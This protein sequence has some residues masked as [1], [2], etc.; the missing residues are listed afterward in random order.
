MSTTI[1]VLIVGAG[2]NGASVACH[3]RRRGYADRVLVCDPKGV[4]A[5]A[6][7]VAVGG[8]RNLRAHPINMAMM[9]YSI[10]TFQDL[11][12]KGV[13]FGF[14]QVGYLLAQIPSAWEQRGELKAYF[15]KNGVR[16]EPMSPEAAA[17]RFLPGYV[18]APTVDGEMLDALR[19]LAREAG[20]GEL[21]ESVRT[22]DWPRQRYE[23]LLLHV[24]DESLRR[25]LDWVRLTEPV[26]GFIFGPD[27]GF[28]A[29]FDLAQ[30]FAREA[31]TAGV[32]FRHDS[33]AA[34][35]RLLIEGGRVVG[36]RF[37]GGEE[38]RAR[39]VV[40]CAGAHGVP[41]LRQSGVPDD[42]NYPIVPLKRYL[43][44]T[45]TFPGLEER[46]DLP[47]TLVNPNG[48]YFKPEGAVLVWG[49][50]IQVPAGFDTTPDPRLF[51]EII[52]PTIEW[53]FPGA[54]TIRHQE[55]NALAGLYDENMFDHNVITG[56]NPFFPGLYD[57]IGCSGRGAM[58]SPAVG[59][60]LAEHI[61]EK[62][63]LTLD[64]S[65]LNF[66]RVF[67]NEPVLETMKL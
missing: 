11:A 22:T 26:P 32:E 2:V 64:L 57:C 48:V 25:G 7:S 59:L 49:R 23:D 44:T 55:K 15:A 52:W 4:G 46:R 67:A 40:L 21:V 6:T 61:M 45:N 37:A 19:Q 58:E 42:L 5:G 33:G 1:G 39:H 12:G 16:V 65:P 28:F 13:D 47:L 34:C 38:V 9:R 63:Y 35:E 29:P 51:Q 31:K 10:A 24:K 56:P 18:G 36:A 27:C 30:Y 20:W 3:L 60:A 50:A 17:E 14:Q 8:F 62:R 53:H 66:R 43:F 41:I 54:S